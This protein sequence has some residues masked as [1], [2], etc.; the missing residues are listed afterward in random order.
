[1]RLLR[2]ILPALLL[3]VVSPASAVNVT[4]V[5]HLDQTGYMPSSLFMVVL[6]IA[7]ATL[8]IS[9]RYNDE[10]CGAIAIVTW[11][12]AMWT[13][14]AIDYTSGT[15]MDT[16]SNINV[17]HTIYHPEILTVFCLICFVIS[18]L[19]ELRIYL[20]SQHGVDETNE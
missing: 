15:V 12:V 6:L 9:Y 16:S 8:V 5:T 19:N 17:A 3:L 4:S 13:S 14:R 10:M 2:P 18:I 7:I 1:M 11:F 20:L